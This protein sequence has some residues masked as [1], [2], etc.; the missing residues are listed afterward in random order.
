MGNTVTLTMAGDSA[1]LEK[2]F[3][4]TTSSATKMESS[5]KSSGAGMENAFGKLN[6]SALFLTD[7]IS[8]LGDSVHTLT[9]LNREGADRADAFARA[10]VDVSQAAQDLDQALGDARQAT[11]DLNQAQR[12]GAQAAIDVEQALLDS[13][14]AAVAYA[15]AVKEF[16]KT[17]VEARQASIDMKQAQA[18]L[19][20]AQLDAKQA[21]EDGNQALLDNT[22]A[23]IDAKGAQISL[24]EAHRNAVA[25]NQITV[26]TDR[27]S[28]LAPI[29]FSAIGVM[30]GF[31]AAT[32][33]LNFAWLASPITWI[34][35]GIGILIAAIVLIATKTT[36]FQDIW[37]VTWTWIKS[38]ASDVWAYITSLPQKLGDSFSKIGSFI[39]APFRAAFNYVSD[40]WNGTIGK[41]SWSVPNWIPGIGGNTISA[42]KLPKFH[43]GGVM[44]GAPGSEGLAILQA[45]ER[46]SPV[47]SDGR[48]VLELRASGGRL[49]DL[50]VEIL[51]DAIDARGGDPVVVLGRGNA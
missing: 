15:E 34:V 22:Q 2:A 17:S 23:A 40:A 6:S 8:G 24:N 27:L 41:L 16:G 45:G 35:V 25:P 11:L 44:P 7:G 31:T 4:D 29:V 32:W 21:T 3:A 14:T 43:T 28:A 42:P 36:W 10:Q 50:L 20:Q 18:D 26:W 33:S 1:K 49:S 19:A 39:T 48:M 46:I 13:D 38:T 47:G 37:R 12:D 51:V 5:V 9:N 30:Q